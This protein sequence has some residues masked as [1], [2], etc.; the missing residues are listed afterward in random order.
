MNVSLQAV[1]FVLLVGLSVQACQSGAEDDTTDSEADNNPQETT[2]QQKDNPETLPFTTYTNFD[3]IEPLFS[4]QNDTTYVINFWATWCKPCVEELPYFQQLHEKYA[5]QKVKVILVSLD[6]E[7]Q[8]KT[9]LIP[10]LKENN[11]GPEVALLLDGNENEWIDRVDPSWGGAIPVTVIYRGK[12]RI[13][14]GEQYASYEELQ[15]NLE[16][17]L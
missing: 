14:H 10:F 3:Q 2:T 15:S 4:K 16:D 12:Q 7:R 5:G 13:F 6:F 11:L 9:K 1:L 17:L 8:I